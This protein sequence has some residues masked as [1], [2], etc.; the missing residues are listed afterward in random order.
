M[1]AGADVIP[2]KADGGA[3]KLARTTGFHTSGGV[4]D[5]QTGVGRQ[6]NPLSCL[7]ENLRMGLG[8][9]NGIAVCHRIEE[10]TQ[11]KTVEDQRRITAGGADGQLQSGLPQ[12][13]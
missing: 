7:Q 2:R 5:H 10:I 13:R 9:G 11:A 1:P 4:L 3:V 12:G 6:R 8:V